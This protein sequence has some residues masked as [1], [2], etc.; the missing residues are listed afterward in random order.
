MISQMRKPLLS[1]IKVIELNIL[2]RDNEFIVIAEAVAEAK[3]LDDSP[4][5]FSP[6]GSHSSICHF[7][8][9]HL[10]YIQQL[11]QMMYVVMLDGVQ[12]HIQ[13]MPGAEFD[14]LSVGVNYHKH[15]ERKE[16]YPLLNDRGQH[17]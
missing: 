13:Y 12:V 9:I 3:L 7:H 1:S 15:L 11:I 2:E 4:L 10:F 8:F 6:S 5:L 14:H 17:I 16:S